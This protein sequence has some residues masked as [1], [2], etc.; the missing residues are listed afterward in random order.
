[1]NCN[2][3]VISA[4]PFASFGSTN[5]DLCDT[6]S[7]GEC[8]AGSSRYVIEQACIGKKNCEIDANIW[9]FGDPCPT[10]TKN[11]KVQVVCSL[12]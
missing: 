5:N 4:V 8:H 2:F 10:I 11:L 7:Y 6:I 12:L 9:N 1:L 3:G